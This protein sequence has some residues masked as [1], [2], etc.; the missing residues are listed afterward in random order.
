M[1]ANSRHQKLL[2]LFAGC[3]SHFLDHSHWEKLQNLVV[4][5]NWFNYITN[6]RGNTLIDKRTARRFREGKISVVNLCKSHNFLK[7]LASLPENSQ[8]NLCHF[9]ITHFV[10]AHRNL[11][12]G[13]L[14]LC[15]YRN[16]V[17]K[18]LK[19][20]TANI[21]RKIKKT[22]TVNPSCESFFRF[23]KLKQVWKLEAK[24][25]LLFHKQHQSYSRRS[26]TNFLKVINLKFICI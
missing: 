26:L 19:E 18:Q 15:K 24:F 25:E 13:N 14:K 20:R 1:L 16:E 23:E 7:I 21:S 10:R 2:D 12:H 6:K 17:S 11:D 22:L 4:T 3:P 9:L 8:L 5:E